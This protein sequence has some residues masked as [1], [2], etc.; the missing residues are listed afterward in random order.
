[1]L[2]R[3]EQKYLEFTFCTK[4]PSFHWKAS[5]RVYSLVVHFSRL[6]LSQI[7]HAGDIQ[8]VQF[9]SHMCVTKSDSHRLP[10][11]PP[12]PIHQQTTDRCILYANSILVGSFDQSICG[13]EMNKN[14]WN[15][16]FVHFLFLVSCK[17][18]DWKFDCI[19]YFYYL[20]LINFI[21]FWEFV[22]FVFLKYRYL[23]HFK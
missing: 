23:T 6:W 9:S 16:L 15:L 14:I 8:D 7:V 17:K 4:A 20:I 19:S 11:P 5:I 21:I 13:L 12:P 1:M 22:Y 10:P 2:T 18:F 3:N